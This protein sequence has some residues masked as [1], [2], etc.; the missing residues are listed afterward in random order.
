MKLVAYS[1]PVPGCAAK[2]VTSSGLPPNVIG[3]ELIAVPVTG[4]NWSSVGSST[5]GS[6]KIVFPIADPNSAPFMSNVK[7][8]RAGLWTCARTAAVVCPL[9]FL[10]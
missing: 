10:D 1:R 4:S 8:L 5:I 2:S 6:A 7:P 9:R 3:T